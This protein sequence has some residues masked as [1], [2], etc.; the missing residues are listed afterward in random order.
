MTKNWFA[1]LALS[2]QD[3]NA[4]SDSIG[5]RIVNSINNSGELVTL[6]NISDS[7][8]NFNLHFRRLNQSTTNLPS[9]AAWFG[10]ALSG[11]VRNALPL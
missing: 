9:Y 6:Q 2:L 8:A 3:M 11:W 4:A 5:L 1:L 10:A 7:C